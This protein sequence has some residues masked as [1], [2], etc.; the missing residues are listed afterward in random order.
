MTR[1]CIRRLAL[2]GLAVLLS[3][4][5]AAAPAAAAP[6]IDRSFGAPTPNAQPDPFYTPPA[7][8][9][10]GFRRRGLETIETGE[11]GRGTYFIGRAARG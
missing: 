4:G 7:V 11:A 1:T 8:L 3:G 2:A 9:E 5:I 6:P 10:R